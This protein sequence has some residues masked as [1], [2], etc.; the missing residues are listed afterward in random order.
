MSRTW[1]ALTF[2]VEYNKPSII[3][4]TGNLYSGLERISEAVEILS[5]RG[6]PGTWLVA[7]DQDPE[8]QIARIFPDL[9]GKMAAQGEIGCHFHFHEG[10][11]ARTDEV[12]QRTG[13]GDATAFLR[14]MGFDV[15]SFRGG[16]SYL[17][18]TTLSI[19]E[20]F[21]YTVDS[22]V[23]PGLRE[24]SPE[25][26]V[27]DHKG[28]CGSEPYHPRRHDPW[29]AGGHGILELPLATEILIDFRTPVMS[30]LI[31]RVIGI[32]NLILADPEFAAERVDVLRE[33]SAG[34]DLFLVLS[35]HPCDF[36]DEPGGAP[37]ERINRLNRFIVLMTGRPQ[38]TFTTLRGMR[39]KVG[40]RED[41][42]EGSWGRNRSLLTLTTSDLRR[43]RNRLR[44]ALG[45][46]S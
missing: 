2:D 37:G 20:E 8:N 6:V 17:D 14:A 38:V 3:R 21:G 9:I 25:G 44:A 18:G 33:G 26:V 5:A 35:A 23:V 27:I 43:V 15:T 11:R 29:R 42:A 40:A 30:L 1:I 31:N 22:S 7:H 36:L 32:N 13:I 45:T 39:A 10:R 19:L 12:F 41:S 34:K 24:V 4:Q 28:R 16:N 46:Q